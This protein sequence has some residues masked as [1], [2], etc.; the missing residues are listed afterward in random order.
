MK[1]GYNKF[2]KDGNTYTFVDTSK[3]EF[4]SGV[5]TT[6]YSDCWQYDLDAPRD[7]RQWYPILDLNFDNALSGQSAGQEITFQ[8]VPKA[9]KAA[10]SRWEKYQ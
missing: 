5:S 6:G 1:R 8:E 9:V 7:M 4:Y 10:Y 2:F 3:T